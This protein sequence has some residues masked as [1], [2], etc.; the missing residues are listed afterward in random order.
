MHVKTARIAK[1]PKIGKEKKNWNSHALL[2]GVYLGKKHCGKMSSNYKTEHLHTLYLAVPFLG[3]YMPSTT[4]SKMFIT[5]IYNSPI[6]R[7]STDVL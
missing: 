6:T 3:M 2:V 7:H 5:Y 4:C 1:I